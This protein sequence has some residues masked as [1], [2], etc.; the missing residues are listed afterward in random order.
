MTSGELQMGEFLIRPTGERRPMTGE[1]TRGIPTSGVAEVF[2]VA[3]RGIHVE[4]GFVRW[5]NGEGDVQQ[6]GR[7]AGAQPVDQLTGRHRMTINEEGD[8]TWCEVEQAYIHDTGRVKR[9]MA[10][11]EE[12]DAGAGISSKE[13]LKPLG[14]TIGTRAQLLHHQGRRRNHLCVVFPRDDHIVPV[15]AFVMSRLAPVVPIPVPPTPTEHDAVVEVR[16]LIARGESA[17]VE[18]KASARWD[19]KLKEQNKSLEDSIVKSVGGFANSVGGVL[20]IGVADDGS[21]VGLAGDFKLLQRGDADGFW[22][23]L[24]TLFTTRMGK[25]AAAGVRTS[26]VQVDDQYVCLA[27]VEPSADAVFDNDG[28]NPRFWVRMGNSTRE[29]KGAEILDYVKRRL[30][31]SP[32]ADWTAEPPTTGAKADIPT[33]TITISPPSPVDPGPELPA[34]ELTPEEKELLFAPTARPDE[35]I[36]AGLDKPFDC[37]L[38]QALG[39]ARRAADAIRALLDEVHLPPLD[40]LRDSR[41]R[42]IWKLQDD[43]ATLGRYMNKLHGHILVAVDG[44]RP[45]ARLDELDRLYRNPRNTGDLR[46]IASLLDAVA[47]VVTPRP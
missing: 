26:M 28:K 42:A 40:V 5:L 17:T 43:Q 4:V 15:A 21:V 12:L 9:R 45:Y 10:T 13:T 25:V 36:T 18:F 19:L 8:E 2:D 11:L 34:R 3:G 39:Q 47:D 44:L 46:T 31:R 22:T 7:L 24:V 35:P 29:L 37:A 33:P 32:G 20:L 16:R 41:K 27:R 1:T 30:S 6:L 23:W 38:S 14:G